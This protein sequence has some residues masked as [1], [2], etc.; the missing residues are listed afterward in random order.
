MITNRIAGTLGAAAFG[1]DPGNGDVLI[2]NYAFN[3][4]ERLVRADAASSTYP[5]KLSDTGVF[6]DVATLTPNPG[7]FNSGNYDNNRNFRG[8]SKDNDLRSE[9]RRV[10]KECRSRWSPYH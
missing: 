9:E 10:G 1:L 5:A 8:Q 2:A 6:A 4:I 3:R 7:V